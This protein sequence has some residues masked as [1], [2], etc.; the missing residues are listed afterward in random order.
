[1]GLDMY[2]RKKILV[3]WPEVDKLE[4][5]YSFDGKDI[6]IDV[7]KVVSI[8]LEA[9]YWRKAN[10]IHKWFVDNVQDGEDDCGEYYVSPENMQ[11]LL[12]DINNVLEH[13]QLAEDLIPTEDGFFFGSTDYDEWYKKDLEDT[14]KII[15]SA[16]EDLKS[17]NGDIFSYYYSSSW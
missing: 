8:T 9:G 5:S 15:E 1:M 7:T 17:E 12:D 13:P 6:P 3:G 10:A 11:M 14:K 16:L 2:L 4:L